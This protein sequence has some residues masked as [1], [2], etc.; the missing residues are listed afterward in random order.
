MPASPW[1][2]SLIVLA[3]PADAAGSVAAP[4]GAVGSVT[5]GGEA[6]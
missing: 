4:A 6:A 5:A 2:P 1:K 3:H